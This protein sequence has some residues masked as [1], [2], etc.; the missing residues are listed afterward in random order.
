LE[1]ATIPLATATAIRPAPSPA[2]LLVAKLALG[3]LEH[4]LGDPGCRLAL[5]LPHLH[6]G[7]LVV[8]SE[9]L[10]EDAV[11]PGGS[12][13]LRLGAVHHLLQTSLQVTHRRATNHHLQLALSMSF[14]V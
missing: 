12:G 6:A 2:R 5:G 13:D 9:D 3:L 1:T 4:L 14:L 7:F 10:W 11:E 8:L